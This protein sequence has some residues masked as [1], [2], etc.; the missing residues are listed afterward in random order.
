MIIK[1]SGIERSSKVN[2]SELLLSIDLD[3][4]YF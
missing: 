3:F 4:F 2:I 1:M